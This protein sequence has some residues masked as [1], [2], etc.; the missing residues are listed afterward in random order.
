MLN[1]WQLIPSTHGDESANGER[2]KKKQKTAPATQP[3]PSIINLTIAPNQRYVVV[4]T[5]DKCLRVLALE[6]DGKLVELSQRFMPKRP[7]AVE[8]LPSNDTILCGDKFGDVYSLPLLG[9]ATDKQDA[10]ARDE[11]ERPAVESTFKPQATNLTV[12]TQ[13]NR[14]ALEA[15]MRQKN[16]TPKTK[17]PLKFEHELL[18]GHVSM[19][20]DL[21]LAT[22]EVNGQQRRYII[23]ADRDEHIRFSRAPP[24]AHIIEGYCLGHTEFI[25]NI[26]LIPNTNLLVSGGGDDWLGVWEWPSFKLRR[27]LNVKDVL[28]QYTSKPVAVSGIWAAPTTGLE[29]DTILLVACERVP[30]LFGISSRSLLQETSALTALELPS[31]PL[32]VTTVKHEVVVSL[33]GRAKA[34]VRLQSIPLEQWSQ[35]QA[36][37]RLDKELE[38]LSLVSSETTDKSL[39]DLLYGVA[40]L[41]KRTGWGTAEETKV[42]HDEHEDDE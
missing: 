11:K 5:D 38:S 31:P 23:T 6:E 40:N 25:N 14:K 41:R 3:S 36:H 7:C 18:L 28:G 35:M 1:A 33:D 27:K 30:A 10:D 4:V 9:Q 29:R 22:H 24:Q 21:A 42:A 13:R 37:P 17:E 39:D 34:Q 26:C 19:L 15:Q 32:D 16:V 20:T 2:P 8:V 12:H